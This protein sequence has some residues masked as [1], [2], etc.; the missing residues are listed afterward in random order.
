VGRWTDFSGAF[1]HLHSGL[2]VDDRRVV[3]T[4]LLAGATN[5][6]L[7]RMAEACAIVSYRRLAWT[8][9]WHLREETR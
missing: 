8:A 1:T 3:L 5:L 2:P 4:A 9:G 6:G 7:T